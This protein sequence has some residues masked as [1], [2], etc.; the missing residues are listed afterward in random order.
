MMIKNSLLLGCD[1]VVGAKDIVKGNEKVNI[2]FVAELFNTKHGLDD[3][4][5][6]IDDDEGSREER[7]FRQW[8]NSLG[9]ED[10][11][12][13]NLY[14]DLKDGIILCKVIHKIDPK[15]VDWVS[16]DKN[17]NIVFKR[18]QNCKIAMDAAAKLGVKML[19]IGPNDIAT[20]HK[21]FILAIVWQLC[22]LHAL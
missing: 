11:F 7:A 17:P 12:V 8:I 16:V 5:A 18:I 22:R 6:I 20:G 9:I 21:Q 10:I 15:V 19:G 1:E 4:D 3:T 14:H 2:V 13:D